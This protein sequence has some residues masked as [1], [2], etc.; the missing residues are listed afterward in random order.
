LD[1]IEIEYDEMKISN[2]IYDWKNIVNWIDPTDEII[3]ADD[4]EK[5]EIKWVEKFDIDSM[6][7]RKFFNWDRWAEMWFTQKMVYLQMIDRS[8]EEEAEMKVLLE[9]YKAKEKFKKF[10]KEYN[11]KNSIPQE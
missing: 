6:I 5:I 3:F 2:P 4:Y 11:A 1:T 7:L 9:W 8:P 10:L